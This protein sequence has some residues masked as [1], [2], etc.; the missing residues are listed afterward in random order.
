MKIP[1]AT[2]RALGPPLRP[3]FV[4][5]LL[6]PASAPALGPGGLPSGFSKS[7][8]GF[9]GS[10]AK[11]PQKNPNFLYKFPEGEGKLSSEIP[12]QNQEFLINSVFFIQVVN[13]SEI[14]SLGGEFVRNGGKF[15]H[16]FYG[17]ICGNFTVKFVQKLNFIGNFLFSRNFQRYIPMG[18]FKILFPVNKGV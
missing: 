13:F 4:A 17:G 11:S 12:D 15:H 3:P 1:R 16:K 10:G 8:P 18:I 9:G 2:R 7:P 14:H 5:S 6:S